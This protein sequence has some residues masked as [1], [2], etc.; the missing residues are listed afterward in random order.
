VDST[1]ADDTLQPIFQP[2]SKPSESV[3]TL[4]DSG[5]FLKPWTAEFTNITVRS[6]LN[7]V[8]ENLGVGHA[9]MVTGNDE[10]R[11]ISFYELLLTKSESERRKQQ[12]Q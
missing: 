6:A 12:D 11:I 5:R 9:W 3:I 4:N 8:A 2:V 1:S 10:V 7:R